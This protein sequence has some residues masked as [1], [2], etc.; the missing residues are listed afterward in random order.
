MSKKYLFII[1]VFE[2]PPELRDPANSAALQSS[3][4]LYR[5]IPQPE[6]STSIATPRPVTNE[7]LSTEIG[8]PS[9]DWGFLRGFGD[10]TDEF[11]ELDV[12]LRDLLDGEFALENVN[13]GV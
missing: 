10:P 3:T 9:E 8:D 12:D 7:S 1:I 5:T 13:F 4:T 6:Y 2:L 11:F